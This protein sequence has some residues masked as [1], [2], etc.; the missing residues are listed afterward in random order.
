MS[1]FFFTVGINAKSFPLPDTLYKKPPQFSATS[2]TCW[3]DGR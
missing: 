2:D 3:R 1:S